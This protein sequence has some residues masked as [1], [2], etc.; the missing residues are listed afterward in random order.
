MKSKTLSLGAMAILLVLVVAVLPLFIRFVSAMEPHYVISGFQD[1]RAAEAASSQHVN[2]VQSN[3]SLG[4]TAALPVWRP[5]PNTDYVCRSPNG[6]DQPCPEG[7]FC[8]GPTQS[9][10]SKYV[11]GPVPTEG[12]YA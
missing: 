3:A 2:Q 8:D 11:G 9:C 4:E 10:I 7:T 1:I 6:S 5:D 12:Y